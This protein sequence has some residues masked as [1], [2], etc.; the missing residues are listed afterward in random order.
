[1]ATA[2]LASIQ[3]L[4]TA[5]FDNRD[6][7]ILRVLNHQLTAMEMA[8]IAANYAYKEN[9]ALRDLQTLITMIAA[10]VSDFRR[11]MQFRLNQE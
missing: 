9:E 10:N 11:E 3:N 8:L 7:N 2:S 4:K 1:M 6:L 5:H